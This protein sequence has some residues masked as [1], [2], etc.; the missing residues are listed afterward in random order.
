[1]AR[2]TMMN[3]MKMNDAHCLWLPHIEYDPFTN[4]ELEREAFFNE[5]KDVVR[6]FYNLTSPTQMGP[7]FFSN[8][9]KN[10]IHSHD[11][12]DAQSGAWILTIW[13][14]RWTHKVLAKFVNRTQDERFPLAQMLAP[15]PK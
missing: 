4:D 11:F 10:C 7:L 3:P 8:Y 1:M 9:L 6:G 15:I 13:L 14:D 2:I 12:I 5:A